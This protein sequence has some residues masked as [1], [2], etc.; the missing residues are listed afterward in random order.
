VELDAFRTEKK[1]APSGRIFMKI[2]VWVF[3]KHCREKFRFYLFL[4]GVMVTV[5]EVVGTLVITSRW[6]LRGMRRVSDRSCRENQT[7]YLSSITFSR[8]SYCLLDNVEEYGRAGEAT[9][10]DIIRRMR[11][12]CWILW[13]Y[14]RTLR[15]FNTHWFYTT[16]LVTRTLLN[17]AL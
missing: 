15:I 9:D 5:H 3:L 7:P 2:R 13:G 14:K 11:F 17:V 6:L 12:E 16:T 1:S 4:T 8:K 10:D